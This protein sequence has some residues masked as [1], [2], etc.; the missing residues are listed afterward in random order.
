[1]EELTTQLQTL[2]NTQDETERILVRMYM[3]SISSLP[4]LFSQD[5]SLVPDY[6]WTLVN[7]LIHTLL[8]PNQSV[9]IKKLSMLVL[10]TLCLSSQDV[11]DRICL[12]PEAKLNAMVDLITKDTSKILCTAF[13]SL[14]DEIAANSDECHPRLQCLVDLCVQTIKSFDHP[15]GSIPTGTTTF[16]CIR[17]LANLSVNPANHTLLGQH[18]GVL[19]L[20]SNYLSYSNVDTCG[21]VA[22]LTC[23]NLGVD[24]S[25]EHC[26]LVM[27]VLESMTRPIFESLLLS[28]VDLLDSWKILYTLTCLLRDHTKRSFL[29]EAGLCQVLQKI[30]SYEN[31]SKQMI[32]WALK[33]VWLL[34]DT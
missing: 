30:V 9:Q 32:F 28:H 34:Q 14:M 7:M 26:A 6:V 29:Q 1:M 20:L 17:F 10:Q 5:E 18:P 4:Q 27:G 23:A 3:L 12:A 8:T 2:H 22:I 15:H 25:L 33:C 19:P 11:C 24:L 16:H 31:A 13:W 21:M